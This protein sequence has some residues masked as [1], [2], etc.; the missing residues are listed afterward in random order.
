MDVSHQLDSSGWKTTLKGLMRIDYGFGAKKPI[1]DSL[2]DLIKEQT[3]ITPDDPNDPPYLNFS[4]YLTKT[5]GRK[6]PFKK[7]PPKVGEED[8][9]E[10]IDYKGMSKEDKEQY[11]IEVG[12]PDGFSGEDEIITIP[13]TG[14]QIVIPSLLGDK[15]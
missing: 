1:V 15:G 7:V 12:A 10:L 14:E 4:D 6:S 9:I 8:E 13:G 2:R 11:K 5:K 3:Q